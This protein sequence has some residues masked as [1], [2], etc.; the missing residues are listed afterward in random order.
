MHRL[1]GG[2]VVV[3]VGEPEPDVVRPQVVGVLD[4]GRLS[5]K[6][7]VQLLGQDHLV[8]LVLAIHVRLLVPVIGKLQSERKLKNNSKIKNFIFVS[9]TLK[10]CQSSACHNF[11]LSRTFERTTSRLS[12]EI[13]E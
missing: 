12:I 9:V 2:V 6:V 5:G 7:L 11:Y 13:F 1:E 8:Q 10:L 3:V 4:E